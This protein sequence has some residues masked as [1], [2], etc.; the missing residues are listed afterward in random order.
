V[1]HKGDTGARGGTAE[2]RKKHHRSI[3]GCRGRPHDPVDFAQV[4]AAIDLEWSGPKLEYTVLTFLIS[5]NRRWNACD[6]PRDPPNIILSEP[7]GDASPYDLILEIEVGKVLPQRGIDLS[8]TAS[9]AKAPAKRP[10][11]LAKN[12]SGYE[13]HPQ[14]KVQRPST[15]HTRRTPDLI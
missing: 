7:L 3:G 15:G 2:I 5:L 14:P 1:P 12:R 10:D 11:I 8:L 4:N 13:L 9:G 6:R